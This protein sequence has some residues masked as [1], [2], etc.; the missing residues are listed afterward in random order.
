M[1]P[2][3]PQPDFLR[4][5][6]R[7]GMLAWAW[8]ATGLA[9]LLASVLDSQPVWQQR[10]QALAALQRASLPASATAQPA[11]AARSELLARKT[12]ALLWQQRLARPWQA[13]WAAADAAAPGTTWLGL[14]MTAPAGA[15]DFGQL[16]L[17][18]LA[19]DTAA[20][21]ASAAAL[22]AL[23]HLGQP[24]WQAVLLADISRVPEGQRFTLTAQPAQALVRMKAQMQAQMQAQM[25]VQGAQ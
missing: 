24:A 22:R 14:E 8:C 2:A 3:L 17:Q 19:P 9:V 25:K 16:R 5:V 15:A 13:V 6:A 12:E 20:A 21:Q 1:R 23:Q 11:P 10:Q 4:P 7:S 18:G